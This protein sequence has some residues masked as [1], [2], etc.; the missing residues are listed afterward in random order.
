[1]SDAAGEEKQLY[2]I[3]R[4]G[5]TSYPDFYEFRLRMKKASLQNYDPPL[6]VRSFHIDATTASYI[7][8]G[9]VMSWTSKKDGFGCQLDIYFSC[10]IGYQAR[11]RIFHNDTLLAETAL[12]HTPDGIE[13]S[14]KET[15]NI[16]VSDGGWRALLFTYPVQDNN[17]GEYYSSDA[18]PE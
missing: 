11:I 6:D 8:Q 5:P 16:I 2:G 15:Q 14:Q 9:E 10:P 12:Y 7:A 13:V 4:S 1:M 3:Y 18:R 17:S